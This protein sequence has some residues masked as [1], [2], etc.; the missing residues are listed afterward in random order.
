[1]KPTLPLLSWTMQD[2]MDRKIEAF[3]AKDGHETYTQQAKDVKRLI[4]DL[5][6]I[7]YGV[8]NASAAVKSKYSRM[9]KDT[10]RE[11][12]TDD[13]ALSH[14]QKYLNRLMS[15]KLESASL[16][17]EKAVNLKDANTTAIR[18]A[19]GRSNALKRHSPRS[20]IKQSALEYYDSH[21]Q[22]F[23]S[24]KDAARA[25]EKRF[26]GIAFATYQRALQGR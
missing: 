15:G 7:I 1:M 2:K 5:V 9:I 17:I 18:S 6:Y 23:S 19:H 20:A 13:P 24:K 11:W 26:P 4:R 12:D 25:L 8:D 16:Y 21:R 10:A 3:R 14:I 22:D